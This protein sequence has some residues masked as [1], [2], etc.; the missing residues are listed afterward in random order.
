[1]ASLRVKQKVSLFMREQL[2][3]GGYGI[4]YRA[5]ERDSG[6]VV[7]LKKSRVSLQVRRT[8]LQHEARILKT[9][10]KHPAIPEVYAYGR[11]K[12]FELLS[13]QL[14]HKC[15]GDIVKDSGP[16][17][18]AVVLEIADQMLDVLSHVHG[19]GIAHRDIKPD[20]MLLKAPNSWKLCLIDFG[21]AYQ[22]NLTNATQAARRAAE[23]PVSICGT[24]PYASLNAH[25]SLELSF[26]DD[27]E[28]LAYTLIYLLRGR[29][30]WS[31]YM[32]HGSI[33]GQLR[34][35]H[36]QKKYYNGERLASGLPPQFGILVDYAR[37]LPR[38]E[39]PDYMEWRDRFKQCVGSQPVGP[40]PN[41]S[42]G[43]QSRNTSSSQPPPPVKPGQLVLARV[44]SAMTVEGYSA[45][46]GH[47]A[48]YI[49]DSSLASP[50]WD[51]VSRPG[52]IINVEWDELAQLYYFT[53]VAVSRSR[54]DLGTSGSITIPILG[55]NAPNSSASESVVR[56]QTNWPLDD[57]YCYAFKDPATFYCLPSQLAISAVW[58][59]TT[60]DVA[61]LDEVLNPG[62]EVLG[63]YEQVHSTNPDTR[64]DARM[65]RGQVKIYAQIS[66]LSHKH[67][68]ST[69]HVDW[70]SRR[71]WFDE[72]VKAS[73]RRDLDDGRWWTGALFGAGYQGGTD[74]S[75]LSDSY[76]GDD[77]ELWDRQQERDKSLTL[78]AKRAQGGCSW[79]VDE[80]DSIILLE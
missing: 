41:P 35:I 32:E 24:V 69:T 19:H 73:R 68:V 4:V 5:V 43:V 47:E 61:H 13:M 29:L 79:N 71:A 56:V 80:L 42:R 76:R 36:E 30:P 45:Q 25:Q 17:P 33:L 22:P 20:N 15:L 50:E 28:S 53:V 60:A 77:Y 46:A 26:R 66:A 14:L 59:T 72:C 21:L 2:G 23:G 51:T 6:R 75:E 34:Q 52:I 70:F 12:H 78:P 18:L 63:Q 74:G 37:S 16:L 40:A 8:L 31:H 48:S 65:R 62:H 54:K 38:D 64:H 39:V 27:L 55:P 11:I 58:E 67:F 49:H 7:A 3:L 44:L 57:A 1:M 10:S 9:L